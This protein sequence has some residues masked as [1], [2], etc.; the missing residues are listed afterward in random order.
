MAIY[1][2]A[3]HCF[4]E[5]IILFWNSEHFLLLLFP[6]LY[7]FKV[8]VGLLLFPYLS[9]NDSYKK[10]CDLE[11]GSIKVDT[12]NEKEIPLVYNS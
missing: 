4:H 1:Q 6:Y 12:T 8:H 9:F 3:F 5:M 10:Q 2:F 7:S 11:S